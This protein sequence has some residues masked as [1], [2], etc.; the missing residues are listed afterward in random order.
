MMD[1]VLWFVFA[2][3][4]F[5]TTCRLVALSASNFQ[6]VL[7]TNNVMQWWFLITAPMAFVLMCGR[8]FQNLFEDIRN[9]RDGA[10]LIRQAVIGGDT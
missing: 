6:I 2:V 8:I 10:P 7:G 9:M 4:V 3:I 5:V 1:H